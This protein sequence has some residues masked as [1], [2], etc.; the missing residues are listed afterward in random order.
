MTS[1]R[2]PGM[3]DPVM[4][5]DKSGESASSPIRVLHAAAELYPW[6]K[7][8]GL[9]DVMAASPP[10]LAALGSDVRLVLPGLRHFSTHSN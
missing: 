1:K 8:G 5:P 2:L 6:V 4:P 7:T 9:G 10:A 3:A